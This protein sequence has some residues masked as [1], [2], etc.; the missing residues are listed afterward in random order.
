MQNLT[1]TRKWEK[2]STLCVRVG[3]GE[4]G[5][6]RERGRE[7][8]REGARE[9]Q[10]DKQTDR[11]KERQRKQRIK[12]IW[13]HQ[14]EGTAQPSKV[15]ENTGI[16]IH[17]DQD[18]MRPI[19]I[20][21]SGHKSWNSHRSGQKAWSFQFQLSEIFH[22]RWSQI[23]FPTSI[24]SRCQVAW[25][26]SFFAL[27]MHKRRTF[28]SIPNPHRPEPP[29]PTL[30]HLNWLLYQTKLDECPAP[31]GDIWIKRHAYP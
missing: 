14:K 5:R 22:F 1:R 7:G 31:S 9:R 27:H 17:I 16:S 25:V 3:G 23:I 18:I 2:Y 15:P 21:S 19:P 4:G 10:I 6:K 30:T 8:E 29:P 20:D 11:D 26:P 12:A 28:E 24:R 13:H